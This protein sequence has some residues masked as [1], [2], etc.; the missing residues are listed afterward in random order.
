MQSSLLLEKNKL[1]KANSKK[2][3]IGK[4]LTQPHLVTDSLGFKVG[5][6]I[7]KS[8]EGKHHLVCFPGYIIKLLEVHSLKNQRVKIFLSQSDQKNLIY[9]RHLRATNLVLL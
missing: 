4:V 6:L 8:L 2:Y 5:V 1:S 7:L 9:Q 3:I